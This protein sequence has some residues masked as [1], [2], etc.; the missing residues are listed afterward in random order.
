MDQKDPE[1]SPVS[2]GKKESD[3]I[4]FGSSQDTINS[5]D[6]VVEPSGTA[7][8]I[9]GDPVQPSIRD[10]SDG[11]VEHAPAQAAGYGGEDSL[12]RLHLPTT[13]PTPVNSSQPKEQENDQGKSECPLL[14]FCMPRRII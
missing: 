6:G 9:T 7:Q 5:A 10:L 4:V 2:S 3:P 12:Q 1:N 13:L 8:S 14:K 11:F